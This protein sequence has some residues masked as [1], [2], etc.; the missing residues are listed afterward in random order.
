[1]AK[2]IF[3][4]RSHET[5]TVVTTKT[6]YGSTSDMIVDHNLY[7]LIDGESITIQS[8]EVVCKDDK[9][10]YI[11]LKNRIDTKIADPNRYANQKNRISL[12]EKENSSLDTQ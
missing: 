2:K 3:K 7:T 5:G 6:A 12:R 11:T 1:M 4:P 10:F 8:N 9:G